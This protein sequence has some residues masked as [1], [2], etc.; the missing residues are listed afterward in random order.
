MLGASADELNIGVE[1]INANMF[2]AILFLALINSVIPYV[3]K[4]KGGR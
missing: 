1:Y 2:I 3:G 4:K